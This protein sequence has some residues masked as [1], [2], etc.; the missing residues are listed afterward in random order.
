MLKLPLRCKFCRRRGFGVDEKAGPGHWICFHLNHLGKATPPLPFRR[1][2]N[3]KKERQ[4]RFTEAC[5][6]MGQGRV[7]P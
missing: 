7:L 3:T 1:Y 2:T 4:K 6:L 5:R